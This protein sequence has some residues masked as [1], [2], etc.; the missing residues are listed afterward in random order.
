MSDKELDDLRQKLALAMQFYAVEA[1]INDPN[2]TDENEAD[3]VWHYKLDMRDELN[4]CFEIDTPPTVQQAQERFDY[5]IDQY[6]IVKATHDQRNENFAILIGEH[7]Q[8][9]LNDIEGFLN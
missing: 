3:L 8:N 2:R 6:T 9:I 4:R 1:T 5:L 7:K